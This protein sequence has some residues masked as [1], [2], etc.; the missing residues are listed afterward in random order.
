MGWLDGFWRGSRRTD[1]RLAAWRRAW[2]TAAARVDGA[3]VQALR[4]DLDALALPDEEVELEREMLDGLEQ[5]A[6]LTARIESAGLPIV[7]TGHR[8]V[9][10]ERCHFTAPASMPDDPLQ[11]SGRMLLTAARAIFAGGGRT[12]ALA[13]HTVGEAVQ[14]DRDLVL[15]SVDRQRLFRFRCNSFVDA[16]SGAVIS[17]RLSASAKRT[18]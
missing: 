6:A 10:A 13:W 8:I 11:P 7:E 16:L 9:G 3:A 4:R 14:S 2:S 1:A 18:L 15:V 12:V 5:A 17:H